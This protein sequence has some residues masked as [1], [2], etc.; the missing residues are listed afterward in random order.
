MGGVGRQLSAPPGFCSRGNACTGNGLATEHVMFSWAVAQVRCTVLCDPE[1]TP[2]NSVN[3]HWTRT[4]WLL[5][6]CLKLWPYQGKVIQSP[7][8]RQTPSWAWNEEM[9]GEWEGC[10]Y[11]S[12]GQQFLWSLVFD[13]LSISVT[14]KIHLALDLWDEKYQRISTIEHFPPN[15]LL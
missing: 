12:P 4:V 11:I 14:S 6:L 15:S 13:P 10:E 2:S 9:W 3:V 1:R 7:W 5:G 8:H